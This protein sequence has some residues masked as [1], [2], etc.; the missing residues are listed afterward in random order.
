MD[1]LPRYTHKQDEPPLR[2]VIDA[3]PFSHPQSGGFR[4]YVRAL[5]TG[6]RE[7]AQVG[8][9]DEELLLY[10]DRPLSPE[11][12]AML[13]LDAQTRI[14]G[15]S[16]LRADWLTFP[17]LLRQDAPD[18]VMGTANYLPAFLPPK[19]ATVVT[20][21][22]AMG[23]ASYPWERGVRRSARERFI[24]RYWAWRTR[25]AART[26]DSGNGVKGRVVT[27]SHG[28]ARELAAVLGV[29]ESRLRVVYNGI[30]ATPLMSSEVSREVDSLLVIESPDPRKN[31]DVVYAARAEVEARLGRPVCLRVVA[32]GE[33]AAGRV[34]RQGIEASA[35]LS[36][37]TDGQLT[38]AYARAS[39]FAWPSRWE[40]FGLPPLEAM[41]QGCAVV[42]S[43]APVMP[44]ILGDVPRYASPDEPDAPSFSLPRRSLVF[45]KARTSAWNAPALGRAHAATFT[46]RRMADETV[47]IWR[48]ALAS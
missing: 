3:R 12:E 43:T 34:R 37:L 4:T 32:N 20:I 48:E 42:S 9:E 35:V 11:L 47:A 45:S 40:G 24:N 44:E 21:H 5:L 23:I 46:C 15:T 26:A 13:P 27:V 8:V 18:L 30:S 6:L 38:E 1:G 33:R 31:V 28:A 29:A 7:R 10:I 22:D 14:V 17:R 39:V 41:A 25:V 16:R 19:V 36:G 2:V